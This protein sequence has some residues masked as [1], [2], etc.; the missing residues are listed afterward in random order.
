[1]LFFLH[2]QESNNLQADGCKLWACNDDNVCQI[3][4]CFW[5]IHKYDQTILKQ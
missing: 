5:Q 1:M 4:E 3:I 2:K